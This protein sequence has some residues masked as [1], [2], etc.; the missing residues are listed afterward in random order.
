[1]RP[2]RYALL[3]ALLLMSGCSAPSRSHPAL[4]ATREFYAWYVPIANDLKYPGPSAGAVLKE[5]PQSLTSELA[6]ALREDLDA[7]A[8]AHEIVGLDF[9]P[10]LGTQDPCEKYDYTLV[11]ATDLSAL[12]RIATAKD[13]DCSVGPDSMVEWTLR[14]GR[15]R[16]ANIRYEHGDLLAELRTLRE[17]REHTPQAP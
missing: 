4:E 5:R 11:K 3:T 2:L 12:V 10:F 6:S 16:I 9:E 8:K 15:W 17:D 13:H 1:M 14:E 7:Q